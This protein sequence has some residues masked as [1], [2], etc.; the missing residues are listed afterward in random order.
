MKVV[1]T[2]GG[3]DWLC[4]NATQSGKIIDLLGKCV[5]VHREFDL[6]SHTTP[7][8][9]LFPSGYRHGASITSFDGMKFLSANQIA[10]EKKKLRSA[11]GQ[12]KTEDE[13]KA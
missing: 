6:G 1:L 2:I 13:T 11:L 5:P 10:K 8:Y 9:E 7:V 4:P 12:P 3:S